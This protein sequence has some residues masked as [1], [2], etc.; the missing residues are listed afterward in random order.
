MSTV[1]IA[2]DPTDPDWFL[3]PDI[4]EVFA[5]L[6]AE[7]PVCEYAPGSHARCDERGTVARAAR[8]RALRS[9]AGGV[10]RVC[11]VSSVRRRVDELPGR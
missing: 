5:T 6:R 3:R 1:A 2:V 9:S 11:A 7:D 8:P 10:L 4:D